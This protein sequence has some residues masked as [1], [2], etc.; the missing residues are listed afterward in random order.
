MKP[1]L[2]RQFTPETL[3]NLTGDK[4]AVFVRDDSYCVD[5]DAWLHRGRVGFN[6][7]IPLWELLG[8]MLVAFAIGFGIFVL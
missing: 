3:S 1:V 8:M 7:R 2:H 4:E 6:P 5:L